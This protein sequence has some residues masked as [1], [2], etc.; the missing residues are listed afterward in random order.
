MVI[1]TTTLGTISSTVSRAKQLHP[2][3]SVA[4]DPSKVK[5]VISIGGDKGAGKTS[6]ALAL[7]GRKLILS[8]DNLKAIRNISLMG[9]DGN[10]V[11][12]DAV[13]HF[14]ERNDVFQKSAVDSYYYV[15]SVL[16]RAVETWGEV[17]WVIHDGASVLTEMADQLARVSYAEHVKDGKAFTAF[18]P[19][20]KDNNMFFR[21]RNNHINNIH[22]KSFD[23]A[24]RGVVY[25]TYAY[26][27]K[28]IRDGEVHNTGKKH[29]AWVSR[30]KEHTD[31]AVVIDEV[32]SE[33]AIDRFAII[34]Y[35]KL[36][37]HETNK[38]YKINTYDEARKF[39]KMCPMIGGGDK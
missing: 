27:D 36:P 10:V 32:V 18:A 12:V 13:E 6:L 26:Y 14:S 11:V 24:R 31:I 17:D 38:S 23:V 2:I 34:D 39:W 22:H 28:E 16:D 29:P 3:A 35:T 20:G 4:I 9:E 33:I 15:E 25:C 1:Y 21:I 19:V 30:I 37:G 8:Y 5:V 7:P